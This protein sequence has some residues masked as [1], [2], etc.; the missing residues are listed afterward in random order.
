MTHSLLSKSFL[1]HILLISL[2]ILATASLFSPTLKYEFIWDDFTFI[3]DWNQPKH[4]DT[5]FIPLLRGDLPPEHA[6]VYRPVRSLL[7]AFSFNLF[8]TQPFGYHLQAIIVHILT[9]ITVYLISVKLTS[10]Q[11]LAFLAALI[12]AVH[13]IHLETIT[14]ITTSFDAIGILFLLF[15]FY[16]YLHFRSRSS[17]WL[18]LSAALVAFLAYFT[19]ELTLTLPLLL[20]LYDYILSSRP[21]PHYTTYLAFIIPNL[22]YWIVRIPLLHISSRNNALLLPLFQRILL[23][24]RS[25]FLYLKLAFFPHPL[26]IN[27]HLTSSLPALH[28]YDVDYT[29][30][31]PSLSLTQPTILLSTIVLLF[32]FRILYSLRHHRLLIF[33]SCWF[34]VSLTPVLN[35]LPQ[36]MLFAEKYLYLASVASSLLTAHFFTQYLPQLLRLLKTHL[37]SLS[38][39]LPQLFYRSILY[40]LAYLILLTSTTL[41]RN[42]IWANSEI[43]WSTALSQN[44]ISSIAH[45]NLGS[46]YYIKHDYQQALKHYL[47]A[48]QINPSQ[49]TTHRNL[50]LVYLKFFQLDLALSHLLTA[51]SL[52]PNHPQIDK[53]LGVTYELQGDLTQARKH[54]LT[55]LTN[56]PQDLSLYS[57]IALTY[58]NQQD[59]D[60]AILYYQKIIQLDPNQAADA[61]NNLGNIYYSKQDL[62]Q[63]RQYFQKALQ[64]NPN[65]PTARQ[66][67]Q[68]LSDQ[69]TP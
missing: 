54:Y 49:S 1:T 60:N 33:L 65:H 58:H 32:L 10:K 5:Q 25:L 7:Y 40:T 2:L 38:P 36:D 17:S 41:I 51:K 3:F 69:L 67:L 43:F 50:G 42:P 39:F 35:I 34:I 30:Y 46:V 21:R 28:Y 23:I 37:S 59:L 18:L 27:H 56:F 63:A 9:V 62:D 19:Y 47:Q 64:L 15:S 55:A 44:P 68:S 48:N 11:P 31:T 22:F 8:H 20:I 16:L 14:F 45:N 26:N 13:P 66:N 57:A 24:T 29:S 4:L 52:E 6:G 61:Y 12:F 53:Y